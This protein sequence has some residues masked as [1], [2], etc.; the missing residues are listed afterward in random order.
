MRLPEQVLGP[1]WQWYW[2]WRDR[3]CRA[4]R[5]ASSAR[6]TCRDR[7]YWASPGLVMLGIAG[8]ASVRGHLILALA[9]GQCQEE[10]EIRHSVFLQ[11]LRRQGV[12]GRRGYCLI[13][14]GLS[15]HRGGRPRLNQL[16][17]LMDKGDAASVNAGRPSRLPGCVSTGE[18]AGRRKSS[19]LR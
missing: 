3:W 19:S 16:I 11:A 14:R 2:A 12:V 8:P 6:N 9:K 5:G 4:L 18:R 13:T 17:T 15:G 7:W 10:H 1:A